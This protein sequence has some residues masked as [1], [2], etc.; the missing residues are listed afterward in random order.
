MLEDSLTTTRI[1]WKIDNS[2]ETPNHL[3]P[4]V[5]LLISP[6]FSFSSSLRQSTPSGV[7]IFVP[8][9]IAWL[10]N[11]FSRFSDLRRQ[12]KRPRSHSQR[13][14]DRER[15]LRRRREGPTKFNNRGGNIVVVWS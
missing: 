4:L 13:V 6:S 11:F 10:R 15:E 12:R 2:T 9:P 8:M 7:E 3:T 14:R 1:H 5:L